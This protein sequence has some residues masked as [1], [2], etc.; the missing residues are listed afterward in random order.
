MSLAEKS[1]REVSA[2]LRSGE[3]SAMELLDD[4]L[5]IAL[6]GCCI[7]FCSDLAY[8]KSRSIDIDYDSRSSRQ[9]IAGLPFSLKDNI[10]TAGILTTCNSKSL[11]GNI[12][13]YNAPVVE[14]LLRMDGVL[15]AKNCMREFSVGNIE[16]SA[17]ELRN[18]LVLAGTNKNI[19]IGAFSIGTD[20]GLSD[21]YFGLWTFAPAQDGKSG[22]LSEGIITGSPA[23]ERLTFSARRADDIAFLH[24]FICGA[25]H[26]EAEAKTKTF[27][28]QRVNILV[29]ENNTMAG[30]IADFFERN[31]FR[32]R[33]SQCR[34]ID[35]A[36]TIYDCV[37]SVQFF[38]ELGNIGFPRDHSELT[39][40]FTNDY[41]RARTDGLGFEVKKLIVTGAHLLSPAH[42]EA[43]HKILS[44][45]NTRFSSE[46]LACLEKHDFIVAPVLYGDKLS[47]ASALAGLTE[48]VVPFGGSLAFKIVTKPERERQL[49]ALA[50]FLEERL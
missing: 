38:R 25:E 30:H 22:N 24:P 21:Y 19:N 39:P 3:A 23:L 4:Y 40:F 26:C 46:M 43:T 16:D 48:L 2:L 29:Y 9:P 18:Y 50:E 14:R 15:T 35:K 32:T 1:L 41:I 8:E 28:P 42:S 11:K 33:S 44:D 47:K 20:L 49:L 36:E 6:K 34:F 31:G 5:N 45:Y 27:S 13:D 12:P 37:L 10:S 7:T 17:F